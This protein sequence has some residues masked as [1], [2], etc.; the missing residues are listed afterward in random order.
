MPFTLAA[1]DRRTF[2]RGLLATGL[3]AAGIGAAGV[4][5]AAAEP[6]AKPIDAD[7]WT[8]LS[9]VHVPADPRT[10]RHGFLPAE[11]LERVVERILAAPTRPAHVL[12][13]G[14]CAFLTGEPGD[15]A[16]LVR[17]LAP[18]REAGTP[19]HL[20]LGN[21]DRREAF[22]AVPAV[23]RGEASPL[24]S[25]EVAVIETPRVDFFLL[26]SLDRINELPGRLG[27]QQLAWLDEGLAR[28]PDKP[29]VVALHHPP[30]FVPLPERIGLLDTW[31]LLE[32]IGRR[33]RVKAV[34]FG[35][36]HNWTHTEIGGVHYIGLPA[37]AYPFAPDRPLGWV[38]AG[39][40]DDGM[41]LELRCLDP[42]HSEHGEQV[43][44]PWR[45]RLT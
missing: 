11:H 30:E 32:V 36:L 6:P 39:L 24:E 23:F 21:H 44:F 43:D 3:G 37:T 2:A 5:L 29:A 25:H 35:H 16:A 40:R 27:K 26:D 45:S 14:D 17:R 12:V 33:L 42:K 34:L 18:I 19:I 10:E 20:T 41:K 9:D 38:E 22:R 8:I 4:E 7:R 15:Y 1:C 28:A 31:P 13:N